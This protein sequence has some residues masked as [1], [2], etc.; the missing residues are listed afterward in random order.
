MAPG[1]K[2]KLQKEK[3]TPAE[4][5]HLPGSLFQLLPHSKDWYFSSLWLPLFVPGFEREGTKRDPTVKEFL[6]GAPCDFYETPYRGRGWNSGL[7]E[8]FTLPASQKLEHLPP[9]RLKK[10][11]RKG[12]EMTLI[13][14]PLCTGAVYILMNFNF[15]L[16]IILILKLNENWDFERLGNWPESHTSKWLQDV[17]TPKHLGTQCFGYSVCCLLAKHCFPITTRERQ[18]WKTQVFIAWDYGD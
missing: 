7:A 4:V 1:G 17:L 12:R 14:R 2:S 5:H 13:K 10:A 15:H 3:L 9:D 8:V 6:T 11:Q 16:S 18:K